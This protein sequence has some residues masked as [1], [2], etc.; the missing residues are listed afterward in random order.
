MRGI[1]QWWRDDLISSTVCIFIWHGNSQ[2]AAHSEDRPLTMGLYVRNPYR[3]AD[4]TNNISTVLNIITLRVFRFL[5]NTLTAFYM[6]LST[7]KYDL[8]F[9]TDLLILSTT[10]RSKDN[11]TIHKSYLIYTS[12]TAQCAKYTLVI[13]VHS[14]YLT[15][16]WTKS[17]SNRISIFSI[18][19]E[20]DII[21]V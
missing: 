2:L 8:H 7:F 12:K 10:P 3:H 19:N 5:Y 17:E 20:S 21:P 15:E 6:P 4:F 13:I 16:P 18:F 9:S 11:N 1:L 14:S